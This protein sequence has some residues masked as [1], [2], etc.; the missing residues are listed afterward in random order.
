MSIASEIQRLQTDS[1][2]IASAISAKGVTVPSGS[3]YDEYASLIASIPQDGGGGSSL[4]YTPLEYIETDGEAYI[5][6]GV[7]AKEPM[8]FD[9]KVKMNASSNGEIVVGV[10]YTDGANTTLQ[11]L[12]RSSGHLDKIGYGYYYMYSSIL[13]PSSFNNPLH[14]NTCL[15][16][17]NCVMGYKA[18]G[19]SSF[20]ST[21][22]SR[23]RAVT[24][25]LPLYIFATN[26]Q[27]VASAK[28]PSGTRIYHMKICCGSSF[29]MV[30]FDGVPA[31]YNGEY[32]LWDRVSNTFF[33]NAA[34][35]GAFTGA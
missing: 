26:D 20:I 3:G 30:A 5:N 17:G 6:S 7:I 2:A 34:D 8:I 25:T 16:N 15:R 32:G 33:G 11:G 10:G 1:A 29:P 14:I 31:L 9:M 24:T 23:T 19:G 22:N 4:P 12:Y 28:C 27:G 35:S 21:T 13:T 18:D